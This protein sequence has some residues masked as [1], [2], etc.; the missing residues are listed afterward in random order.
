[1]KKKCE[2]ITVYV[3]DRDLKFKLVTPS[4]KKDKKIFEDE[5]IKSGGMIIDRSLK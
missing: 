1:M 2:I 4:K 5:I 3:P